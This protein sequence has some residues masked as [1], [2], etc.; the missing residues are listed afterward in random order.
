M[1]AIGVD[2]RIRDIFTSLPP[3]VSLPTPVSWS[4]SLQPA[5]SS[6][7]SSVAAVAVPTDD[8]LVAAI[9]VATSEGLSADG[10]AKLLQYFSDHPLRH[11][12]I[13]TVGQLR[14]R[15]L[16]VVREPVLSTPT[17]SLELESVQVSLLARPQDPP[18]AEDRLGIGV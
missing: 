11:A 5:A 3:V 1:A 16:P 12:F 9:A 18:A 8:S 15:C 4:S 6:E 10:A 13:S 7:D 14:A 17:S 2:R